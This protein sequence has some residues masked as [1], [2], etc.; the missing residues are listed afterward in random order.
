VSVSFWPIEIHAA[1]P[2]SC[3]AVLWR[4]RDRLHVTAI[5]K[6]VFALVPGG[7]M[8]LVEPEPLHLDD[9]YYDDDPRRSVRSEGE[10]APYRMKADVVVTGRVYAPADHDSRGLN[11]RVA[12]LRNDRPIIDKSLNVIGDRIPGFHTPRPF[13]QMPL[14]HERAFGGPGWAENPVGTGAVLGSPAPN[15]IDPFNPGRTVGFGPIARVWPAR[16]RLLGTLDPGALAGGTL[17]IPGAFDWSYFQAAPADQRCDYLRGD[18]WLVL[19]NV[20]ADHPILRTRLPGAR[21]IGKVHRLDA[22]S[23]SRG[24]NL[25]ADGMHID[26]ERG[27]CSITWRASLPLQDEAALARMRVNIGIEHGPR[28]VAATPAAPPRPAVEPARASPPAPRASLEGTLVIKPGDDGEPMTDTIP[29]VQSAPPAAPAPSSAASA[30]L[31]ESSSDLESTIPFTRADR[32]PASTGAPAPIVQAPGARFEITLEL[33]DAPTDGPTLPFRAGARGDLAA[34][35]LDPARPA[36][37]KAKKASGPEKAGGMVRVAKSS[38]FEGTLELTD[39]LPQQPALPFA[40]PAPSPTKPVAAPPVLASS[41]RAGAGTSPT[42]ASAFGDTVTGVDGPILELASP[43]ALPGRREESSGPVAPIPGAPWSGVPAVAPPQPLS[44]DEATRA[45]PTSEL[46]A[47]EFSTTQDLPPPRFDRRHPQALPA[48]E[49]APASEPPLDPALDPVLEKPPTP[50][51][52]SE[53]VVDPSPPIAEDRPAPPAAP[54]WSW[55]SPDPAEAQKLAPP[56]KPR[57]AP[58]PDAGES[59]YQGFSRKKKK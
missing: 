57:A 24:L 40:S 53:P 42:P 6:G 51:P 7:P 10:L 14:A 26:T 47:P 1:G 38:P 19:E 35:G 18:E 29:F 13:T 16:A 20:Y 4:Y 27:L 55:A 33:T 34:R 25:N 32:R 5:V 37:A 8:E 21:A 56:P 12:V 39:S 48:E 58:Q 54:T 11:V 31:L 2:T 50:S 28:A 22:D 44:P 36:A 23:K 46:L 15:L 43:F 52:E 45:R 49:A 17:E 9:L 30:P 59:L 3:G 41:R